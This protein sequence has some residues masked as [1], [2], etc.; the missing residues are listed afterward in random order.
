MEGRREDAETS[1][2]PSSYILYVKVIDRPMNSFVNN[3]HLRFSI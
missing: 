1:P 3:K 2:S